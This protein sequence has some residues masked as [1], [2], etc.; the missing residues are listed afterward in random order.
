MHWLYPRAVYVKKLSKLKERQFSIVTDG[1]RTGPD[2]ANSV[3]LAATVAR[4]GNSSPTPDSTSSWGLKN[5]E[6]LF[7]RHVSLRISVEIR[8]HSGVR[9]EFW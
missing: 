2:G 4:K 3:Q 1:Q 8:G 7:E 6:R 5:H 9:V